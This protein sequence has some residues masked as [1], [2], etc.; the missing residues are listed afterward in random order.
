[1]NFK[2][3][4]NNNKVEL[5][6]LSIIMFVVWGFY[7]D[8]FKMIDSNKAEAGFIFKKVIYLD[9]YD[10]VGSGNGLFGSYKTYHRKFIDTESY[11]DINV[12]Q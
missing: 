7:V 6:I 1:M 12:L 3:K 8:M 4:I 9:K 10:E 11:K 2:E 5:I